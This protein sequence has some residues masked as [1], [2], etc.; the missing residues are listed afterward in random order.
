[1]KLI[2]HQ[3]QSMVYIEPKLLRNRTSYTTIVSLYDV[4]YAYIEFVR[5]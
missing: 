1:M 2:C 5:I 3:L 4:K